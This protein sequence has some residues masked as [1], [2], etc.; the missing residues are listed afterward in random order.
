MARKKKGKPAS[1]SG[2]DFD[3]D[4]SFEDNIDDDDGRHIEPKQPASGQRCR[5]W[6]DVE[7]IKEMRE[8]R[9]LV[10]DDLDLDFD[11]D[12]SAP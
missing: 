9:R 5:D 10:D 2:D 12:L 1:E 7:K 3:D 4:L 8:L 6:R 11:D